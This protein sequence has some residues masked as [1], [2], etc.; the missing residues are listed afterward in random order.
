MGETVLF[1]CGD[2]SGDL[3]VGE[4]VRRLRF[5]FPETSVFALG[6]EESEKAGAE[7][8]YPTVMLSTF[9]LLELVG[10]L[11][12]WKQVWDLTC[13]FVRNHRPR[14]VVLVDNPGFNFHLA[15]F[16]Q[17]LEIPV[18]YF[19]PPQVWAWG[20]KRGVTLSHLADW[21]FPLFPWEIPY[22]S[23][24]KARV[25]W[26]GHPMVEFFRRNEG[27]QKEAADVPWVVL[28]PGS[29]KA[30]AKRYLTVVR[31]CLE[32]SRVL[33]APYR[34]AAIAA[35]GELRELIARELQGLPVTVKMKEKL[36]LVLRS[37]CLA[38]AC[39]GTVT[40]EVALAG[41]PQII[42]YRLSRF[43]FWV[44]RMVFRGSLVGLPNIVLGEEVY[45]ELIQDDFSWWNL[46]QEVEKILQ[47]PAIHERSLSWAESIRKRLDR[48][49]PFERVVE[50]LG[51]YL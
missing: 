42:V 31:A 17:R 10:S 6:G 38:I 19:A 35:S 29:R 36:P 25:E 22:F 12:R 13:A 30:E 5:S 9:G 2:V 15:R 27:L 4:M 39:A 50:V 45:P 43:T 34:L 14:V 21:I 23:S 44:A 47:N 7:L 41:V 37:A 8:L 16:C 48:G 49:N 18:V 1:S 33:F 46:R 26:A 40:L 28:L 11:R 51:T 32:K 24:G 20:R 3:Y